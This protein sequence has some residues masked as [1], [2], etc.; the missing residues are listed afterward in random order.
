MKFIA[1]VLALLACSIYLAE[2][3]GEYGQL[4]DSNCGQTKEELRGRITGGKSTDLTLNPWMV[5][6]V[7]Q[8]T[9]GGTLIT[10]RFVLTAAHCIVK[11]HMKVYLGEYRTRYPGMHNR[12]DGVSVP[13]SYALTVDKKIVHDGYRSMYKYDIGLLRMTDA[14]QYSDYVQPICL[15]VN[16]HMRGSPDYNITGWGITDFGEE[17]WTLQAAP[18]FNTDLKYCRKKFC[19]QVDTSQICAANN[20]EDAC[21]GD[22]GGP[23]SAQMAFGDSFR[24]FQ[25]GIVSYGTDTCNSFSVYTNVTHYRKWIVESIEHH[26]ESISPVARFL[27]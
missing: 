4:L 15:L 13:N 26:S 23:L 17:S 25:Y 18:V 20:K 12:S 21:M 14:V 22:S 24:T 1:A 27:L 7:G 3:E 2:G 6:V 16:G 11:S 19:K 8:G 5:K 9:C 10:S